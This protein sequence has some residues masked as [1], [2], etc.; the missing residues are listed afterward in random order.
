MRGEVDEDGDDPR[1]GGHGE[2]G[3][4]QWIHFGGRLVRVVTVEMSVGIGLCL[5]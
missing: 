1:R 5:R 2:Q 4:D 3:V